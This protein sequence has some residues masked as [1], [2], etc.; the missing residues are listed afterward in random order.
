MKNTVIAGV[1]RAFAAAA[2]LAAASTAFCAG[3][4]LEHP[5]PGQYKGESAQGM[6]IHK[7]TAFLFNNT[8]GC[9]VYNLKTGALLNAFK[10]AGAAP[11]NHANCADFGVEYPADNDTYPA[12]YISECFGKRRC[13][14]ESINE[15]GSK[16]LQTLEL[17]SGGPEELP[18][19]WI[20][21]REKKFLYAITLVSDAG[22]MKEA[23]VTKLRLPALGEGNV[24][25]AKKDIIEQ[26]TIR[27][28][29][30]H[31]GGTIRGERLYLPLGRHKPH[32]KKKDTRDRAVMVVN[33]RTKQ[34]EKTI[35]LSDDIHVEPEDAAFH[36]DTLLVY[37]GQTGGLWRVNGL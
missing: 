35:D 22:G 7:D 20:V 37:C 12:I 13:L 18:Y 23:L 17:K 9:R 2:F 15:A 33:L 10:L 14:V 34:I 1:R 6:T 16:L 30:L 24:I 25:F 32:G 26:F 19:D 8:G 36:G 27:F 31:Q 28:R 11:E 29:N 21:D 4:T 3:A 5:F